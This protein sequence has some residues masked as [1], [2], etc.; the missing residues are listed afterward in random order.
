MRIGSHALAPKAVL[1]ASF[2]SA[3]ASLAA[4]INLGRA[5]RWL[6]YPSLIV[7]YV[8]VTAL[9]LVWSLAIAILAEVILTDP[10]GPRALGWAR[11]SS[12][13]TIAAG[14]FL[15]VGSLWST[16][17]RWAFLLCV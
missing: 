15:T 8:P 11:D 14:A 3:R 9:M 12:M 5:E 4:A 2:V 6:I 13:G 1:A 16:C 7:V 10:G 17:S